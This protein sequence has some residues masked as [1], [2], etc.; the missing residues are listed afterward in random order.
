MSTY[1][2]RLQALQD[3]AREALDA[4][5]SVS[6]DVREAHGEAAE[7]LDRILGYAVAIL[8]ATE[9]DLLSDVAEQKIS[10]HLTQFVDNPVAGVQNAAPWGSGLLDV[11]CQVPIARDHDFA[12]RARDGAAS[13]QRST[14]QRL[15]V[16][17]GGFDAAQARIEELNASVE[18]RETAVRSHMDTLSSQFEAKLADFEQTLSNER[19]TINQTKTSQAQSFKE[20]QASR[21]R[22]Y[23][24][25]AETAQLRLTSCSKRLAP[26]S[27]S[28]SGRSDEWRRRAQH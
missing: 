18:E 7:R 5:A 26:R 27:V 14:Q 10:T 2:D 17:R 24:E 13:Y 12:Q 1:D 21:D 3:L 8:A 4:I 22:V 16:L 25:A 28:A 9:A 11:L 20:A 19:A 15:G 23:N 6:E